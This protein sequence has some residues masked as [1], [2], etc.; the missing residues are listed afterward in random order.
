M[1]QGVYKQE[2]SD[3]RISRYYDQT[4]LKEL[5]RIAGF[6]SMSTDATADSPLQAAALET[7]Q[8][9]KGKIHN[10]SMLENGGRLSMLVIFNDEVTIGS[11]EHKKRTQDINEQLAGKEKAGTI[12]VMSGS[13][14][15]TVKEMGVTPK[16]MDWS[17]MNATADKAVYFRF[18]IPIVITNTDAA[19]FDNMTTGV[20]MLYDDAV[21]PLT[22]TMLSGMSRFLLPRFKIKLED[23]EITFN[24][25]SLQPLKKRM[26]NELEQRTKINA[27]TKNELRESM[28]NR[29]PVPGGDV[30]YQN[31]SLVE[32]GT[33]INDD[34]GG[35]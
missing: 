1:A 7:S 17:N 35:E 27:E 19:T 33:D 4:K 15:Q 31:A 13:D 20:E 2:L 34:G 3:N 11:D 16:D 32:I 28:P 30:I 25:D 8:Q 24:R 21:I 29:D 22:N 26:L 6:S 18:R 14:I 5:Y 9:L 23:A 12:G 10:V